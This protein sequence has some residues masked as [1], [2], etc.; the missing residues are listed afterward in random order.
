MREVPPSLI[1]NASLI[2]VDSLHACKLEAGELQ[3]T[4]IERLTELGKLCLSGDTYKR[5]EGQRTVF[6]SVGVGIQDVAIARLVVDR[7][8]EGSVGRLVAFD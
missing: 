5:S 7:A 2:I 1:D 3:S 4:P 8:R 6:K